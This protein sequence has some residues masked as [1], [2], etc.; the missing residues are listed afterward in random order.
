MHMLFPAIHPYQEHK[1]EVGDGHTLHVEECGNAQGIPVLFVHG[2]PGAGCTANDRCFFDPSL[3][4]IILFDQRGSGRSTPHASLDSN[5]SEHLAQDIEKI[6]E[7]LGIDQWVLFGGSWGSTLSLVYAIH[8]PE[9]VKAMILR[10]IFLCREK[11]LQWFYQFGASEI[12]PEYWQTYVDFIPEAERDNF[13]NAYYQRL[14]GDD[15]LV[16]MAA[17]KIWSTWEAQCATLHPNK[18]V[19]ERFTDPHNARSIARIEAHFFQNQMF[20]PEN[21]ILDNADKF[22]NIPGVIIHG[23][24]DMVCPPENALALSAAWPKA[25]LN[26]VRDAGHASAEPSITDALILATNEM[27]KQLA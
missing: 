21:F 16:Q 2:G 13:I 20:F 25:R 15:E 7:H 3:Y 18:K 5:T 24:Y 12:F 6:R 4:R 1:L 9:R 14:T 26:I 23:R 8:Y 27:A 11:D 19:V 17:A 22:A 10:G